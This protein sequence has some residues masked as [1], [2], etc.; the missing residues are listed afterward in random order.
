M[1]GELDDALARMERREALQRRRAEE[2]AAARAG[3]PVDEVIEAVQRVVAEHRA[4]AVTMWVADGPNISAMHVAWMD[5]TVTVRPAA[6]PALPT[7][8][9]PP[10]S[11][12]MS[13][14]TVPSWAA[15]EDPP[16]P[17]AAARLADLIRR[18]PSLLGPD[19]HQP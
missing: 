3:S 14:K 9:Q 18:D 6:E 7:A 19:D 13:V 15:P 11:W 8:G 1:R 4:L 17:D 12:P 16:A 10:H 5:G 2:A